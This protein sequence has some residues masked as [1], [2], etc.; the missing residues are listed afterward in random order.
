MTDLLMTDTP[1]SSPSLLPRE[2]RQQFP[3][4]LPGLLLLAATILLEFTGGDL[5]LS[6]LFH[7]AATADWPW[8][9]TFPWK[10]IDR[11]C[12]YP[13]MLLGIAAVAYAAHCLAWRLKTPWTLPA[14]IV[15]GTFLLGPGLLVNGTMKPFFSRPRPKEVIELG[16]TKAYRPPLGFG[17]QVHFNSSFPSGHA[18]IGFFLIAPAFACRRHSGWRAGWLCGGLAYGTLMGISRIVQGAHY[19]SDVLWSLAVVYYSAWFCTALCL[20]YEASQTVNTDQTS[21]PITQLPT[22][23]AA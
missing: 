12:V 15:A 6:G 3:I 19:T 9:G 23:A 7:S 10:Q 21:T 22:Q 13:G 8:L 18:S 2:L 11:Y 1:L 17:E 5:R 4:Y 14:C 20:R 16:G